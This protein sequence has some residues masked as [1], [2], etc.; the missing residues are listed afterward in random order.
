MKFIRGFLYFWYDFI[1]GDA[2]E[3]AAGVVLAVICIRMLHDA[4]LAT[5]YVGYLFAGLIIL[6][7]GV[8][9]LRERRA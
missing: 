4:D 8:S 6:L 1:I 9:L 3:V 2:W 7:L 5:S